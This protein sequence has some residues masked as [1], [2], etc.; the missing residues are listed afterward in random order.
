MPLFLLC[1]MFQ[2]LIVVKNFFVLETFVMGDIL[3]NCVFEYEILLLAQSQSLQPP[4]LWELGDGH[5]KVNNFASFKSAEW[6]KDYGL[7]LPIFGTDFADYTGFFGCFC[8]CTEIQVSELL[9]HSI[10][11]KR[12]MVMKSLDIITNVIPGVLIVYL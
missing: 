11:R 10:L 9:M 12:E 7:R 5:N 6:G 8:C 3:F 4:N 2:I 1:N